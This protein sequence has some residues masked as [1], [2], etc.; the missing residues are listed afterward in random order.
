M[1]E[2]E[3]ALRAAL[4]VGAVKLDSEPACDCAQCAVLRDL[5]AVLANAE[6][7]G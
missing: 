5:E 6:D 2:L 7:P 1:G 4:A 3:Q